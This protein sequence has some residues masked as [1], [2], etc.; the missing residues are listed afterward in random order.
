MKTKKKRVPGISPFIVAGVLMIL[1]PIFVIMTMDSIREQNLRIVEKLTGKG[2]FLIRAFEAGTRTG[3]MT[4]SWG[5][6]RVQNLL[7]ETAY[8]PEVSY[9]MITAADGTILAH[10]DSKKT[11]TVYGAM[12][13]ISSMDDDSGVSH[14]EVISSDGSKIFEVF[15][16]FTPARRM[17]GKG[18]GRMMK[19]MMG[20][21][22]FHA[23]EGQEPRRHHSGK[24][25]WFRDHFFSC[26]EN[27]REQGRQFIFAGLELE[28]AESGKQQYLNHVIINGAV[29]L[30]FGSFG[31][32]GLFV[33][34]GYRS[35]R[36]SL[37]LVRAF[38]NKVVETM[39]AGLIAVN[40][41]LEVTSCNREAILILGGDGTLL[42]GEFLEM[43]KTMK[44]KNEKIARELAL[45]SLSGA[46]L[47]LD[48]SASPILDD[49]GEASGYLFLFRDLTEFKELKIEV[50]R[51][52]RLAA[53]G[54]FAAGVAHEIR[55]PLSSIKGFATYFQ[56]RYRDVPEDLE[57]AGIMVH[58]VERLNRSITQL[59]E[60][61]K[62][63]PIVPKEVDLKEFIAHSIKLVEHD[64]V[65]KGIG[66]KRSLPRDIS[67]VTIDPDKL[68]QILLNLYLNAI[69]A[70]E[71]GGE[72]EVK[73]NLFHGDL[74]L[75]VKDTGKGI[76]PSDLDRIFDPYFTTRAE[77][78]GLGLAMVHRAVEAM[79]GE[80]R[81]ESLEGRGTTF[82]L[83][84]PC[85]EN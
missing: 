44:E 67:T 16:V 4:K 80:I 40:L 13:D 74:L 41:E 29:L 14:R 28:G 35:A 8:Q 47:L 10:S 1:V 69:Q 79:D 46:S 6:E 34:Q 78:T 19:R 71:K 22:S 57:I 75:E 18:S 73:V 53:V 30:L 72:L 58:E 48:V 25:D 51:S 52:R 50:E 21:P 7:T 37:Y 24:E 5:G 9:I 42:P 38:S 61:A 31:I 64:L 70:M 11:G 33:I 17:F 82:F 54:K 83:K 3:M 39:P 26:P 36:S 55:N 66:V 76:K 2:T 32:V 77:G 60:F 15:K 59:L 62:P 12:P 23:R 27:C 81:V 85:M 43:A 56:E 84:L 68:N 63:I 49:H 65:N 20:E 45:G